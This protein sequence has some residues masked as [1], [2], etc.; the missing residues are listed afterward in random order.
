MGG[1]GGQQE[2]YA[3]GVTAVFSVSSAKQ[4]NKGN[5]C[6][7]LCVSVRPGGRAGARESRGPG[8]RAEACKCSS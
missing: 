1:P 2:L 6:H 5:A 3:P 8:G 7:V 4:C